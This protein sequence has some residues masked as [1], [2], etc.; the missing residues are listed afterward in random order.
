MDRAN[1]PGTMQVRRPVGL[2]PGPRNPRNSV[3]NIQLLVLCPSDVPW[4][5]K[6]V[7]PSAL[8][9]TCLQHLLGSASMDVIGHRELHSHQT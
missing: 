2:P 9:R 7:Q 6:E 8:H 3:P 4:A 1:Q 5:H